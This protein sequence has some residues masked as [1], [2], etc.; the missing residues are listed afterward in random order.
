MISTSAYLPGNRVTLIRGGKSYF[1]LLLQ[2]I[3]HAKESI[4]LQ[5]Y[6]YDDDETGQMIAVALKQAAARGVKVYLIADG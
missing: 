1:D 5:T 2:L 6:I 3:A 4:H